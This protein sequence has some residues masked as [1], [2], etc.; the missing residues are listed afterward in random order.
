MTVGSE[1]KRT[2]HCVAPLTALCFSEGENNREADGLIHIC[3]ED[4]CRHGKL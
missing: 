2:A 4:L 3:Y 1:E